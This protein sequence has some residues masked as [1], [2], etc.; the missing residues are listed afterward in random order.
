MLL[1]AIVDGI[2][3]SQQLIGVAPSQIKQLKKIIRKVMKS[4]EFGIKKAISQL[5]VAIQQF[6]MIRDALSPQSDPHRL[7]Q[8]VEN[9][10]MHKDTKLVKVAKKIE[11]LAPYLLP[12]I[13]NDQLPRTT[14]IS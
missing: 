4:D 12:A 1:L 6:Q 8:L 7:L 13:R 2:N 5:R 3:D 14:S 10:S 11:E 9:W